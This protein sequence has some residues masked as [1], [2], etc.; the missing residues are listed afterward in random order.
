MMRV[1][2]FVP[3][4]VDHL[5]PS[6]A[7]AALR[8]LERL[9]IA[10]EVPDGAV[11]CGQPVANAGF[12]TE[13]NQ[14]LARLAATLA[15]YDHVVVLSGSCAA[16][17]TGHAA[18]ASAVGAAVARRTTEFCAFLYDVVGLD[19]VRT[20]GAS[21]DA[22]VA[23]HI[24]CHALRGLGLARPSELQLPAHNKVR[25]LLE[26]VDGL[27]LAALARPDECCGFGGSF[28]VAEPGVSTRMGRDR[29]ADVRSGGAQAL[30]TT[31]LSCALHLRGI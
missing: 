15:P 2:L 10:A 25:A 18:G 23:L 24:G 8:V 26:T 28:S 29:L 13:G 14:A 31:D 27:S 21:L 19:R 12:A 9:G 16:H 20:L 17:V 4:F 22:R 6:A 7:I 5:V 11:C 3:C 1:A 30:V